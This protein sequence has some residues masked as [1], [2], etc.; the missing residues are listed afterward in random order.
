MEKEL[1]KAGSIPFGISLIIS[2]VMLV[3]R[4]IE[5]QTLAKMQVSCVKMPILVQTNPFL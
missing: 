3:N 2:V 1:H 5:A 4:D